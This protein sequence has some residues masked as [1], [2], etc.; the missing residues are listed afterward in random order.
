MAEYPGLAMLV[1]TNS[2]A[3]AAV[4]KAD[5]SR[6]KVVTIL[7]MNMVSVGQDVSWRGFGVCIVGR[8]VRPRTE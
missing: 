7:V 4:A 2:S 3:A 5:T 8:G 1:A 6:Q